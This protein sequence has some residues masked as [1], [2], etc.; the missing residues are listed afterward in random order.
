MSSNSNIA[1]V[2]ID[3]LNDFIHPDGKVYGRV[4]QSLES[5]RAV[6]NMQ[7]LVEQA[8]IAKI[9]IF[10]ALHQES[11]EN[12]MTGWNHMNSSLAAIK[13]NRVFEQG[14]W[15]AKIFAGLEPQLSN[16]DVVVSRH[17]NSRFSF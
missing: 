16:G 2:L 8:R 1:V 9:P 6:D 7:L 13:N 3:P 12:Y 15:G 10:Y 4:Q 5:K 14:S 17:W 11:R